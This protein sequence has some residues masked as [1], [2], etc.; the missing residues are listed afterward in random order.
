MKSEKN[1]KILQPKKD[2]SITLSKKWLKENLD[3]EPGDVVVHTKHQN[4]IFFIKLNPM[5]EIEKQLG[6]SS[7]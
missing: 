2:G 6:E 1:Y 7:S 3:L 4:G 5:A